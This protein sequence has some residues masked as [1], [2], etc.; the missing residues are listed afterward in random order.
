MRVDP[1]SSPLW[2]Q[3]VDQAPNATVFHHPLWLGLLH[4]QY[5]YEMRAHVVLDDADVP[6]AGLPLALISS[7]LT[8][9]RLV[10]VPFSDACPALDLGRPEALARLSAAVLAEAAAADLP[11]EVRGPLPGVAP[12]EARAEFHHHVL[13]LHG[14][15]EAT[16]RAARSQARR[17]ASKAARMGVRVERRFDRGALDEFYALHVLTRRRQGVPVQS[18]GFIRRFEGLFEAGLGYVA[19]ARREKHGAAAA[20][21]FLHHGGT[22]VYKYG[23]SDPRQ[24]ELRP[25]HAIFADA[26]RFADGAAL[27]ELDFGRTD[28]GQDGLR[29]FKRGWGAEERE[30]ICTRAPPREPRKDSDGRARR[31]LARVIRRSPPSVGRL[32]GAALYRHF[33]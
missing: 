14:D 12:G 19:I 21:V 20:A 6:V 25:N 10:A 1:L 11:L 16:L 15:A 28:F 3:L 31:A 18:R 4:E 32:V 26:I 22:L 29:Q 2:Q 8:G 9:R 5:G 13:T 23:A 7:R 30:L 27:H 17:G 33:G 24:L